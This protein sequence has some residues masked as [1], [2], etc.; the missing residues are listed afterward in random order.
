[1][2]SEIRYCFSLIFCVDHYCPWTNNAVGVL[3]HR[4]FMGFIINLCIGALLFDAIAFEY[5]AMQPNIPESY[6]IVGS[7]LFG[8]N[9]C[10]YMVIHILNVDV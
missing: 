3:N 6:P 7:C 1:M 8:M 10:T 9:K 4:Y 2:C 5:L